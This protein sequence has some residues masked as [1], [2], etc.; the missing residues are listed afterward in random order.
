MVRPVGHGLTALALAVWKLALNFGP[1][2]LQALGPR[3][4]AQAWVALGRAIP[5][6]IRSG[7]LA[8]VDELMGAAP[9]TV[10]FMSQ[11]FTVDCPHCDETN[12]ATVDES[13][14]F[15]LIRELFV[16]NCYLRSRLARTT[17]WAHV[18]DGGANRGLFSLL[19]G[20]RGAYVVAVEPSPTFCDLIHHHM[21][22]NGISRYAVE[23]GLLFN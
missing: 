6:V 14:T 10:R 17:A 20:A 8:R 3:Q 12:H 7:T 2:A 9:V 4:Y 18:V 19:A 22:L 21:A 11:T 1:H 5:E 23:P 15:G 16:R 13:C